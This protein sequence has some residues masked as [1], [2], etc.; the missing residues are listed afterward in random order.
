MKQIRIKISPTGQIEAE[1]L[2][3]HGKECLKYVTLLEQMTDAVSTDSA[4]TEDYRTAEQ[5]QT[6]TIV[7]TEEVKA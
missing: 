6:E 2:G 5:T 4:F 7:N 1:T 3:M